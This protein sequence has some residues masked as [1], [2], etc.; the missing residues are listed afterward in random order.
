[1]VVRT[2]IVEDEPQSVAK[3][4]RLLSEVDTEIDVLSSL[5]NIEDTVKWLRQNTCDLIFQDIQLADGNSFDIF[6]KVEVK[7]P[8][9]FTTAYD[10]FAIQAFRQNS[11]DYLLKPF[12]K[13][14]LIQALKK[15]ETHYQN[16]NSELDYSKLAKALQ[17]EQEAQKKNFLIHGGKKLK[18]VKLEEVA[19]FFAHE[20][21]T[22][23]VTSKGDRY[24]FGDTL[25]NLEKQL[26]KKDFFRVN[27]KFLV[28][29]G[30]IKEM[31]YLAAA[32]I[33]I[34]LEPKAKFDITVPVEKVGQFK[35]WLN[36]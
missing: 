1:M 24:P 17:G 14:D 7:T 33:K 2:I 15:F 23:L 19:Y 34:E 27:R 6:K 25:Q 35:H 36:Q 16:G 9:I 30:S 18:S 21:I 22:F 32:R 20:K 4:K 11:V 26:S 31:Y 13:E 10:E 28:H 5:D 8:I 29:R 12:G 3:L